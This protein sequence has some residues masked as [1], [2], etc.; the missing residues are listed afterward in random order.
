MTDILILFSV[1]YSPQCA[2]KLAELQEVRLCKHLSLYVGKHFALRK[3]CS[4]MCSTGHYSR[5]YH[6]CTYF[7]SKI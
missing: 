7:C 6:K 3:R 1:L 2:Q 5:E 4:S